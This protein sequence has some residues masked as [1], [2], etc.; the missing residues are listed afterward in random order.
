MHHSI[1][2]VPAGHQ[3]ECGLSVCYYSNCA[4][5]FPNLGTERALYGTIVPLMESAHQRKAS[6]VSASVDVILLILD[7]P[8]S[9]RE[10]EGQK[11]QLLE[12]FGW[13]GK[14]KNRPCTGCAEA[15]CR[16][17][18]DEEGATIRQ[19]QSELRKRRAPQVGRKAP[20]N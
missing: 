13:T 5:S 2:V 6:K 7:S 4:S 9:G 3:G 10:C 16:A 14:V 12:E 17:C 19:L 18:G 1:P 8:E 20:C 11:C 15:S